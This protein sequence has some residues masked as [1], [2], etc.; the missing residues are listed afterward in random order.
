[1]LALLNSGLLLVYLFGAGPPGVVLVGLA[2]LG[3][4]AL[5]AILG[6]T[7]LFLNANYPN[8]SLNALFDLRDGNDTT[9]TALAALP[10]SQPAEGKAGVDAD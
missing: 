1:M 10:D 3:R 7:W 8:L 9:Q 4:L 6:Y 5:A 2:A